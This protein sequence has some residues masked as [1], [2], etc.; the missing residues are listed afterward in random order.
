MATLFLHIGLPKTGTSSVQAALQSSASTL[1]EHGVQVPFG[2]HHRQRL[3]IYDLMGRRVPGDADESVAGSFDLLVSEIHAHPDPVTVISEELLSLA[4]P[5]SIRKLL[6]AFPDHDVHVVVSIRDLS[7]TICSSWQ[8]QIF[9]GQT[10]TWS[11]FLSAVRD[12]AEGPTGAGVTFWLRQDPLRVLSPWRELVPDDHI[13]LVTVPADGQPAGLLL[14]RFATLLA[15]PEKTLSLSKAPVNQSAGPTELEVLRRLNERLGTSQAHGQVVGPAV[16]SRLGD[17]TS[18]RLTLP[19]E[20]LSWVQERANAMIAEIREAGFP[21]VGDLA[22]LTP[23]AGGPADASTSPSDGELLAATERILT[24]LAGEYGRNQR[25]LRRAKV[26]DTEATPA[27]KLTS[28]GRALGY[29]AR[30]TAVGMADRNRFFAWL[31][32]RYLAR[33]S[34]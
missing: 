34:H 25:R 17:R 14:E 23:L 16:M 15:I 24:A 29:R 31:A 1:A 11:E 19:P 20:E 6:S 13:H 12:P 33:G 7:R 22:D 30:L 18:G 5:A 9:Q 21:V 27:Q 2:R 8:Q 4:R 10:Y 28:S 3:A 32:R 26:I